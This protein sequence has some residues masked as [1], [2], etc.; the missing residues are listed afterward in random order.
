MNEFDLPELIDEYLLGRIRES[1]LARLDYL[2]KSDPL[3]DLQV[4]Q[5]IETF[6]VLQ[7]ARYKELREKLHQID[8]SGMGADR[9]PLSVP[10]V[11]KLVI[12]LVS[13]LGIW[14]WVVNYFSPQSLA[15][16][17]FI[18][19]SPASMFD[20]NVNEKDI[21][22]WERASRYFRNKDYQSAINLFELYADH[23]E[24][25]VTIYAKWNILLARLGQEGPV[26][27]LRRDISQFESEAP[28]PLKGKA[29]KLL[30]TIDSPLYQITV[31]KLSPKWSAFKP[32][33]M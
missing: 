31:V 16:R 27:N 8:A 6:R 11:V 26:L 19:V 20:R 24:N 28:E 13:L 33:L 3:I 10:W 2:R 23:P 32:R 1:D 18:D 22:N 29:K 5:S 15:S 17:N 14:I 21:K 9:N 7:Y 4:R 25:P 12:V 30:R